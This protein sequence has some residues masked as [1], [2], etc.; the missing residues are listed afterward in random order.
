MRKYG[1]PY[2]LLVAVFWAAAA[3]GCTGRFLAPPEPP[4]VIRNDDLSVVTAT[5]QDTLESL[6]LTYLGDAD[7]AWRIAQYNQVGKAQAGQ[8]L[9]IPLRPVAP[10]GLQPDGYQTVPVLY[11]PR[12]V[13]E[14]RAARGVPASTFEAQV[15]FLR[16]NGY[17]T[18][19][20]A[21]LSEFLNLHADLPPKAVVISFDSAERWVYDSAYP[22]LKRNGFTAVL[23]I[24]TGQI[25]KARRL[26]WKEIAAMAAEGFDIGTS[27]I[28]ARSL[29]AG[30]K[31][32]YK[33][34][35]R[36]VEDEISLSQK[37]IAQH[38]KMPCHFF[39]YPGGYAS[40]MIIAL[41]KKHG[42]RL[43]F[44][45]EAGSNP[46]FADDFRLRR[47]LLGGQETEVWFQQ[48]LTT[49]QPMDLR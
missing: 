43:A 30:P 3:A 41:L 48:T 1:C 42:F 22:V 18:V 15:Q 28:D 36:K 32:T 21:Q 12:I 49:F 19:R 16:E 5:G 31:T 47:T 37:A 4:A 10:G 14:K 26:N 6:A 45:R 8:R 46:F 17:R 23:F 27:G 33:E 44:T 13:A 29:A 9:V 34:Y 35:S 7:E 25:D 38:L 24:P 20:L 11:Y 2:V 39:A 40:D